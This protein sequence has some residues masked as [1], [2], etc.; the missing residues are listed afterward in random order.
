MH[1]VSKSPLNEI[2][3]HPQVSRRRDDTGSS[4]QI[5]SL[6]PPEGAW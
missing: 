4:T 6:V 2:P 1:A 5:S 3:Y